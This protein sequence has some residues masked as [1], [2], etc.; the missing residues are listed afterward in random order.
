MKKEDDADILERVAETTGDFKRKAL[1]L[2]HD[3]KIKVSKRGGKYKSLRFGKKQGLAKSIG[4]GITGLSFSI[5]IV[6]IVSLVIKGDAVYFI[7]MATK[8]TWFWPVLLLLTV[9]SFLAT[10]LFIA[11]DNQRMN[12]YIKI[13]E[14]YIEFEFV[15]LSF[16]YTEQL[17]DRTIKSLIKLRAYKPYMNRA[18]V[19]KTELKDVD[20]YRTLL[21]L[22]TNG[23]INKN[24]FVYRIDRKDGV[25]LDLYFYD[26]DH[27]LTEDNNKIAFID[28]DINK[29]GTRRIN[30][31]HHQPL[32][33]KKRDIEKIKD[34][35]NIEKVSFDEE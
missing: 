34:W 10:P 14:D 27:V 32:Y 5:V 13:T 24:N 29:P 21:S 17:L 11:Q 25:H 3:N 22:V 35:F 12:N 15:P 20:D 19:S 2:L 4:G 16:Q 6:S 30:L 1:R 23:L 7:S 18:G 8:N 33:Y 28:I 9:I 31:K 26:I